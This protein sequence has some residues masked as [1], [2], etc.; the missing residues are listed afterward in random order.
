MNFRSLLDDIQVTEICPH[1]PAR[2]VPIPFFDVRIPAGF[3]SPAD[4]WLDNTLDLNDLLIEHPVATFYVRVQGDS[5]EGAGIHCGDILVV[6]R[7][8]E[9]RH[10]HIVVAIVDGEFT[11]K[12]LRIGPDGGYLVAENPAM[13]PLKITADTDFEVWGVVTYAIHQI[14]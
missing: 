9:P 11:I 2:A 3:P 13:R 1:N 5:M 7:A 12:R 10:G 8:V 4:D 14:R 6:D